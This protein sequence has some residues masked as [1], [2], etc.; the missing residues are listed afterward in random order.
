MPGLGS[1]GF[2]AKLRSHLSDCTSLDP[3]GQGQV[4]HYDRLKPYTLPLPP[5]SLSGS[6]PPLVPFCRDNGLLR[7]GRRTKDPC[8]SGGGETESST[9]LCEL[10]VFAALFCVVCGHTT[11]FMV[12]VLPVSVGCCSLYKKNE[13]D[14]QQLVL[15]V[16]FFCFSLCD[17]CVNLCYFDKF[18]NTRNS[19]WRQNKCLC[20]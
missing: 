18:K 4:L 14:I 5:A 16:F 2:I 10:G 11:D 9:D 12:Q 15:F 17:S 1:V 8:G 20:S 13:Y 7:W 6:S 3:T 19:M